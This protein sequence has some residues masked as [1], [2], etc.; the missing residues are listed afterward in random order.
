MLDFTCRSRFRNFCPIFLYLQSG[1]TSAFKDLNI[2]R[3]KLKRQRQQEGIVDGEERKLAWSFLMYPNHLLSPGE[4]ED[5]QRNADDQTMNMKTRRP[6]VLSP[7][8]HVLQ[9]LFPS[10]ADQNWRDLW[11]MLGSLKPCGKEYSPKM[12]HSFWHIS[13]SSL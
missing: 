5:N 10:S 7:I 1:R 3:G 12:D 13:F 11:S 4:E 6:S 9:W 2:S 8:C